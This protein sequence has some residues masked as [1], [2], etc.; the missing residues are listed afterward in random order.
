MQPMVWLYSGIQLAVICSV[1][2]SALAQDSP[3]MVTRTYAVAGPRAEHSDA[4][5]SEPICWLVDVPGDL[6]HTRAR[7]SLS[8][9]HC[10]AARLRPQRA[11]AVSGMGE[12][13]GRADDGERASVTSPSRTLERRAS[14]PLLPPP[15]VQSRDSSVILR[16]ANASM[17]Q[18]AT[19]AK[20]RGPEDV[21]EAMKVRWQD[22]EQPGVLRSQ[23]GRGVCGHY[24]CLYAPGGNFF[25]P[26]L[27]RRTLVESAYGGRSGHAVR[28]SGLADARRFRS[29]AVSNRVEAWHT[30]QG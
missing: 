16:A 9:G 30:A 4:T 19:R 10:R 6:A 7:S 20:R 5:R 3:Q 13:F 26:R 14:A 12:L 11:T 28:W 2:L 15:G 23:P 1:C 22:E 18:S 21:H 27:G 8:C 24:W 17:I 29:Q 25:R